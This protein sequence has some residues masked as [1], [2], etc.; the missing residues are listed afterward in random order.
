MKRTNL[1]IRPP[2]PQNNPSTILL[3]I[4]ERVIDMSEVGEGDCLRGVLGGVDAPVVGEGK[5]GWDGVG[6]CGE[7]SWIEGW[8]RGEQGREEGLPVC[9]LIRAKRM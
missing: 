7:M 6:K 8:R 3:D 5:L 1:N 2:I 4:G 9:L